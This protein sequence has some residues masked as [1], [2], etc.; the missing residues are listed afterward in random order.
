MTEIKEELVKMMNV[1]KP[2]YDHNL[3]DAVIFDADGTLC[4]NDGHRNP[5]DFSKVINDKPNKLIIEQ[6]SFHKN[7]N[8]KIIVVSGRDDNCLNETEQWLKNN[9]V[10][11]DA[12]F[13]RKTGD[14]RKDVIVKKEIYHQN[15][16][17][18]FN[19]IAV[20]DDRPQVIKGWRE[21]GFFV[22]DV[23]KGVDF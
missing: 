13:M 15:I 4:I 8:R 6:A 9:N 19:I 22:F 2:E 17:N 18:K 20:Y 14:K 23:G 11:Y 3:P 16:E 10:V 21:L 5:F 7:Q 1:K 12:I